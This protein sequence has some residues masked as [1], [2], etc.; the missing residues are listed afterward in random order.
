MRPLLCDLISAPEH[1][2][3]HQLLQPGLNSTCGA[4]EQPIPSA[5]SWEHSLFACTASFHWHS[6]IR[7]HWPTRTW[8]SPAPCTCDPKPGLPSLTGH[9]RAARGFSLL[10]PC[11]NGVH[12]LH[13]GSCEF[14]LLVWDSH[15]TGRDEIS[16]LLLVPWISLEQHFVLLSFDS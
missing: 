16:F 9:S 14:V 7:P 5:R 3:S 12:F 10:C 13:K 6:Q 15:Q 4:K 2:D 8:L 11:R 1:R